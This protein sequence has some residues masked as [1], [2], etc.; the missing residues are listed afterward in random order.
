[1]NI[2]ALGALACLACPLVAQTRM[3]R[4]HPLPFPSGGEVT[5]RIAEDDRG[6]VFYAFSA[7]PGP[8]VV[9][10][11]LAPNNANINVDLNLLDQGGRSLLA[12]N[13]RGYNDKS[14]REVKRIVLPRAERLVLQVGRNWYE[15]SG[16]FRIQVEGSTHAGAVPLD[17][18]AQG[19]LRLLMKDGKTID[20]DLAE[21]RE[22]KVLPRR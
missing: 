9:T 7:G 21:V 17:L 3:D 5:G 1:M 13:P 20:M 2:L 6:E 19:T 11:D 14:V 15:G 10:V 12:M 18:P 16:T 8:L 4:N 22:A